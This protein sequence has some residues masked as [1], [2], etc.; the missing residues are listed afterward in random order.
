MAGSTWRGLGA[1]IVAGWR[2]VRGSGWDSNDVEELYG[3]QTNRGYAAG[4]GDVMTHRESNPA[5][6]QRTQPQQPPDP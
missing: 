3:K 6:P 4:L 1:R 2:W 5:R